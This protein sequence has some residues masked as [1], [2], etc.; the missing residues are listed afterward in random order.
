MNE[1]S[2]EKILAVCVGKYS[3]IE[4]GVEW[5]L[6][7]TYVSKKQNLILWSKLAW[8]MTRLGDGVL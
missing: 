8:L 4:S 6:I 3:L 1:V 7:L 5:V 2:L